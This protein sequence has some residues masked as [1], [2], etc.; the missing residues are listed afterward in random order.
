MRIIKVAKDIK[1]VRDLI[2]SLK[3]FDPKAEIMLEDSY[4]GCEDII[5]DSQSDDM[6][7]ILTSSAE[8][9]YD[10]KEDQDLEDDIDVFADTMNLMVHLTKIVCL[11]AFWIFILK[12]AWNS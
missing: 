2:D 6:M 7:V 4:T 12:T 5:I 10:I 8:K 3:A 9:R 11:V 1:N